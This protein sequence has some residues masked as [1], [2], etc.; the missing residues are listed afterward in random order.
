LRLSIIIPISLRFQ[1]ETGAP[2]IK[3]K[4]AKSLPGIHCEPAKMIGSK[5]PSGASHFLGIHQGQVSLTPRF[6]GVVE[7]G[8]FG[9]PFPTVSR[10]G[11]R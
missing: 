10:A 3:D 4:S 9:K 2:W 6:N 7:G 1:Y 5:S 11:N 8:N